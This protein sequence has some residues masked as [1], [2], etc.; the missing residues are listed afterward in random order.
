MSVMG[1]HQGV[2]EVRLAAAPYV[3]P[4]FVNDGARAST[5]DWHPCAGSPEGN[6]NTP[7]M[8]LVPYDLGVSWVIS[9]T[10]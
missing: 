3:R 9:P 4:L 6:A 8:L 5:A 7:S 1:Y 2:T 10:Y